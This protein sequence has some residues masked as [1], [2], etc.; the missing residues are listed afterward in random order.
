MVRARTLARVSW[1]QNGESGEVELETLTLAL[2]CDVSCSLAAGL[3]CGLP[4]WW[5]NPLWLAPWRL[6]GVGK[7]ECTRVCIAFLS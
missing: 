1:D 7:V 5:A 2:C 4:C 3:F 6:Q